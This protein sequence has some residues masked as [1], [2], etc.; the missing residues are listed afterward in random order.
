MSRPET[1]SP[2]RGGEEVPAVESVAAQALAERVAQGMFERDSASR[3]LG[4][5]LDAVRPGYARLSMRIRSDMLNGHGSCH[6]GFLFTLADSAFAFACNS[7][8]E[9]TVAAAGHIEFLRPA[10]EGDVLSAEGMERTLAGRSGV[11]DVTVVDQEGRTVAL[12]R[13]RSSR[14]RGTAIAEAGPDAEGSAA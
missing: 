14:V 5:T 1:P 6:G 10:W 13:G 7:R 2:V 8:N 11:Y 3:A 4:M 12:F 9:A